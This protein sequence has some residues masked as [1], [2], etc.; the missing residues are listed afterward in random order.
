MK[1]K[2]ILTS[3]LLVACFIRLGATIVAQD[4]LF[5]RETMTERMERI[6]QLGKETGQTVMYRSDILKDKM[7]P[8]FTAHTGNMEEWL[9]ES[10]RNSDLV[11]NKIADKHYSVVEKEKTAAPQ[12]SGN[13]IIRGRVVEAETSEPLIGATVK[14]VGTGFGVMTDIDGY[15]SLTKVPAGRHMLEVAY[16][17]YMTEKVDVRVRDSQTETYDVALSPDSKLLE[18]VVVSGVR[19]ERGS[20]PHATVS[21]VVQ[22]IKELQVVASGISSEQ[23]SKSADRNAAQAVAKVAGV[24]IVDDKFVIVRGLNPRYNLTYLN[25]NVAPSTETNSR[26]FAL[27]LIPSRVIDKIVVQKSPSPDVQADATG[28]VIKIYTKDARAVKHLDIDVQL[29]HRAGTSFNNDF[30]TY[31]GGKYDILG[32]DDGTRAL[33]KGVPG[34]GSLKTAKLSPS[35]YAKAFNPTFAYGKKTALPNL[36]FTANY[37][38]AFNLFGKTLSSLTSL[39]YKNENH[40][41][42]RYT[43]QGVGYESLFTTDR[44]GAEDRN[45][46]TVQ[47][48][49]LQ[50]FTYTLNDKHVLF[51]KN[52]VLQQGTDGVVV[53]DSWATSI[54][55]RPNEGGAYVKNRDINLTYDQRL[56]YAGNLGGTHKFNKGRHEVNWNGG[57]TFSRQE[58]PDQRVVRLTGVMQEYAVGDAELLW[59]ARG[60]VPA[61]SGERIDPV[62]YS[63]GI[64]SRLWSRNSEG[65]YNGSL[66]YNVKITPWLT[67]KAGTFHQWKRR[68]L[69]RRIYT[70]HEG[71]MV[72]PD[73]LGAT[74]NPNFTTWI[75][76]KIVRFRH[77][78]LPEVW[79]EAYLKDD[80]TGLRVYDRTSGA[81]TYRGTE[82]NNSAYFL[83]NIAP[84][85]RFVE[86]Y[87]GIRYEYNRQKIAAAIP[88]GFYSKINTPILVD[89]PMKS[90]LPSVSLSLRPIEQLVFRAAY[91]K[92]V[93][94]TEFREVSPFQEL[95]FANNT[96]LQGNPELVSARV[97]NYDIRLEYYPRPDKGD[98]ISAGVFY[99]DIV[100]PIERINN[101]NRVESN[102]PSIS[103]HNAASAKVKGVEVELRQSFDFIPLPF[104]RNLSFAGNVSLIESNA[105]FDETA[106][107]EIIKERPLQ[108]QAPYLINAGLYYENAAWGSKIGVIYNTAGENI[109]A[110]GL[111]YRYN[112]YI[113]GPTYRGG[114]IELPRKLLDFSYTQRIG[115]GLQAKLTVQNILNEA[116]IIAEDYNFSNKYEP[117]KKEPVI[118]EEMENEDGSVQRRM[119]YG[120]NFYSEYNPGRYFTLSIS[121]SF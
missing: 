115:K 36:Q 16:L 113:E 29:G 100:N 78:D 3:I 4:H 56:L 32:F 84:A 85:N 49:L 64:I 28:G 34:Y 95:D 75:N 6:K 111:G 79:S 90:W 31:S 105:L 21:Q 30:L 19:R 38:D 82:Q 39:S 99:K 20:V 83:L 71:S 106:D 77:Q 22:E 68:R 24:S 109:Y 66:D 92:T 114:L 51:F 50:N 13:G 33:P 116:I 1:R 74:D 53:R 69:D 48:N 8:E 45:T 60:A 70:V 40:K 101:T 110:A 42:G 2:W 41:Q 98:L 89:N 18:E 15:Y 86:I 5:P 7:A 118:L 55:F 112:S 104:I 25:D 62:P 26:S 27:D 17:G 91:G 97:E 57:Y 12:Q 61:T 59:R 87:G 14:I 81:D 96:L 47:T 80:Y 35:E 120:D 121:Y 46:N 88:A 67:A 94:R 93:N 102:F 23:I 58:M 11:Y 73:Y 10:L 108:G 65:V 117:R 76:P 44:M 9:K 72:N 63:V 107:S 43:Q 103:F 37:Y 119:D 54:L 52:F